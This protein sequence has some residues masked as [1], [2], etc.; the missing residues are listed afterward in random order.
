M[1]RM[2]PERAW[3]TRLRLRQIATIYINTVEY[4]GS[5][6]QLLHKVKTLGR[7]IRELSRL[8]SI[9]EKLDAAL[10]APTSA[11]PESVQPPHLEPVLPFVT[12]PASAKTG[13]EYL[14][15]WQCKVPVPDAKTGSGAY[16]YPQDARPRQAAEIFGLMNG[17]TVLELGSFEGAHAYQ[18]EKMGAE[19]TGI[20]A[21]PDLFTK[22]LAVKNAL[23]LR[24]RFMLGDFHGYLAETDQRYDMI[25][26]C[27]VL[28]HMKQ[29]ID[30]L[31]ELARHTDRV[32]LWTHYVP[33]TM[34]AIW[35]PDLVHCVTERG[36][37]TKYYRYYYAPDFHARAYGGVATYCSRITKAAIID[38]LRFFGLT[39]ITVIH[40]DLQHAGGPAITLTARRP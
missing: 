6:V 31:W 3:L 29:P 24:A 2:P 25:F 7:L 23:D 36:F 8:H 1:R 18:L 16:F 33:E 40:D 21:N 34:E 13:L 39:E 10:A 4:R 17:R 30:L 9:E 37:G 38:S 32:F 5:T 20:E 11:E 15:N 28:Y 35:T 19:V 12:T 26:A 27:G 22:C 14:S